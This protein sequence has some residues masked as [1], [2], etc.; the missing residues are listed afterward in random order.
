M[1]GCGKTT[2][3]NPPVA[4]TGRVLLHIKACNAVGTIILPR[5]PKR[6]WWPLLR[7]RNGADWAP[8]V[9]GV[10]CLITNKQAYIFLPGPDPA[11]TIV[12]GAPKWLVFALRVDFREAV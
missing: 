3:S 9:V 12:V 11:D 1:T 2:G 10:R 4:L 5:W 8:Y 7:A 6:E